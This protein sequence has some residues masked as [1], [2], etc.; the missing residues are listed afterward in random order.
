M[1]KEA[2]TTIGMWI[3]G[4]IHWYSNLPWYAEVGLGIVI[5]VFI[6]WLMQFIHTDT[7]RDED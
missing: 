1:F 2:F 6:I 5:I 3:D 4:T 7:I